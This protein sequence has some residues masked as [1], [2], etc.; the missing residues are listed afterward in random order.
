MGIVAGMVVGMAMGICVGCVVVAVA[1]AVGVVVV[2]V[3]GVGVVEPMKMNILRMS[4]VKLTVDGDRA[5]SRN[6]Y[7]SVISNFS[8]SIEFS[9]PRISSVLSTLLMGSKWRF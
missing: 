6:V 7:F 1:V 5:F 3:V 8:F 2:V 4:C 9:I